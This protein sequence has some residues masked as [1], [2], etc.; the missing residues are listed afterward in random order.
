MSIK[1]LLYNTKVFRF[2]IHTVIIWYDYR[3]D[4]VKKKR[5]NNHWDMEWK[6]QYSCLINEVYTGNW[7]IPKGT[8][9]PAG[10]SDTTILSK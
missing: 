7:F 8:S 3:L 6:L 5:A 2:I 4:L 1:H 9:C 10:Q